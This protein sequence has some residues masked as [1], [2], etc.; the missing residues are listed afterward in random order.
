MIDPANAPTRQ[1]RLTD[2]LAARQIRQ[3]AHSIQDGICGPI[4]MII[5]TTAD[6]MCR[7]CGACPWNCQSG[8]Q[9]G[10]ISSPP[11]HDILLFSRTGSQPLISLSLTHTIPA[12]SCFFAWFDPLEQSPVGRRWRIK[13]GSRGPEGA[14]GD[15][16]IQ[17]GENKY[18]ALPPS[19]FLLLWLM[20]PGSNFHNPPSFFLPWLQLFGLC[21]SHCSVLF[22][23]LLFQL[24]LFS[25]SS[26]SSSSPLRYSR[27]GNAATLAR[28]TNV[29]S[30]PF[31]LRPSSDQQRADS[32]GFLGCVENGPSVYSGDPGVW[33]VGCL[34]GWPVLGS[35]GLL[36][37]A[38]PFPCL[39]SSV[40]GLAVGG[41][42]GGG[43]LAG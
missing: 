22:F 20:Y 10:D 25:S 13:K 21:Y 42:M 41:K 14:K 19:F 37:T 35:A 38:L 34:V 6:Q 29:E 3:P 28:L 4:N 31:F 26:S 33:R 11:S 32:L 5:G 2:S 27:S 23:F 16:E 1:R 8:D 7:R 30:S 9:D 17:I 12:L 36:R 39:D 18:V 24:P 43:Q 15:L 40:S